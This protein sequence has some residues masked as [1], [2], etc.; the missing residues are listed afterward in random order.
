MCVRTIDNEIF[1]ENAT[2]YKKMLIQ[3]WFRTVVGE[4]KL[5]GRRGVQAKQHSLQVGPMTQSGEIISEDA[6]FNFMNQITVF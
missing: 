1:R 4:F 2:E 3:K 6:I 5:S